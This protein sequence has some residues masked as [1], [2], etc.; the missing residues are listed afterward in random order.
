MLRNVEIG[1]EY[2]LEHSKLCIGGSLDATF[3]S[4]QGAFNGS[5]IALAGEAWNKDSQ[6][7]FTLY[8]QHWTG[9]IRLKKYTRDKGW[10]GGGRE[11]TVATDAKNATPIST[12][13]YSFNQTQ[14]VSFISYSMGTLNSYQ[15]SFTFSIYP[16]TTFSAK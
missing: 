10:I 14:V 2:C 12:V 7:F 3:Y 13:S 11:T 5:G 6:T 4:K 1:D 15:R 16:K 9:D 8:F